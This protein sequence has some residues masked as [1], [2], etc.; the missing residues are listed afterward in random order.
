L[1]RW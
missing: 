1:T